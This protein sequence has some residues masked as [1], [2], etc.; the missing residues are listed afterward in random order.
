M[1]LNA[2]RDR[3]QRAGTERP[4]DRDAYTS[5]T[6]HPPTQPQPRTTRPSV[7]QRRL[8]AADRCRRRMQTFN[9]RLTAIGSVVQGQ[10]FGYDPIGAIIWVTPLPGMV[11]P[12]IA[13]G[14]TRS[15]TPS[16]TRIDA[17]P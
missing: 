4:E 14:A 6:D 5:Q 10:S 3:Y 13:V 1:R 12:G 9:L 11:R 2:S 7:M 15:S 8:R 16:T 17:V